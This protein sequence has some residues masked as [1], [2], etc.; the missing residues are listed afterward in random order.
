M[1]PT[2]IESPASIRERSTEVTTSAAAPGRMRTMAGLSS[3]TI[4]SGKVQVI[5]TSPTRAAINVPST[6]TTESS[7]LT[8]KRGV[9]P[10][11]L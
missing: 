5:S 10:A 2:S 4:K 11:E 6:R 8:R 3:V 7:G 9:R 1:Q